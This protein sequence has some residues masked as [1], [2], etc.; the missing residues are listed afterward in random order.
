[1]KKFLASAIVA[2]SVLSAGTS[3][4]AAGPSNEGA[5]YEAPNYF[6]GIYDFYDGVIDNEETGELAFDQDYFQWTN[7]TGA[8][9]DFFVNLDTYQNR[10]LDYK[11]AY[12]QTSGV[13]SSAQ[14][15][16][17]D[18]GRLSWRILLAPGGTLKVAV[19]SSNLVAFDKFVKY[20]ISLHDYPIN[21]FN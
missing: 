18:T 8:Y 2:V 4:F 9:K 12:V 19:R 7:N 1:M 5:T 21:Y 16:F 3:A 14:Q 11:F 6:A 13:G 15:Y 20:R 10:S 17:Y